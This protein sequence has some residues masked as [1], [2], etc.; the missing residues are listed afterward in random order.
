MKKKVLI[1]LS[2]IMALCLTACSGGT[3]P[4]NT[5]SNT[6]A[7]DTS[8]ENFTEDDIDEESRKINDSKSII[9]NYVVAPLTGINDLR[10]YAPSLWTIKLKAST[11]S[12]FI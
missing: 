8:A 4:A 7:I 12:P 1:S 11:I 6:S 9:S 5:S 3:A 10:S 2:I